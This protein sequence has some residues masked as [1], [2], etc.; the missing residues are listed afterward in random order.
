MLTGLILNELDYFRG[1]IWFRMKLLKGKSFTK[2]EITKVG[3]PMI[4]NFIA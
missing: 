4:I 3:N 2:T 1:Y